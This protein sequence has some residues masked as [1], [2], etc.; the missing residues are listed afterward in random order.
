M[1]EQLGAIRPTATWDKKAEPGSSEHPQQPDHRKGPLD[2][3]PAPAPEAAESPAGQ[4]DTPSAVEGRDL[5]QSDGEESQASRHYS[6][7]VCTSGIIARLGRDSREP[8][9][10]TGCSCKYGR[11]DAKGEAACAKDILRHAYPLSDITGTFLNSWK[12]P[13]AVAGAFA[14]RR[15]RFVQVVREL[16]RTTYRPKMAILVRT[17]PPSREI[18]LPQSIAVPVMSPYEHA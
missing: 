14:A 7:A 3:Q 17:S 16:K 6:G 5:G 12:R 13:A 11:T 18:T 2:L 8:C 4:L 15:C 1:N 10:L 9:V